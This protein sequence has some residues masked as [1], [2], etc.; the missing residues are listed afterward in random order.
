MSSLNKIKTKPCRI[1]TFGT[2]IPTIA[3]SKSSNDLKSP[4][5]IQEINDTYLGKT[6]RIGDKEGLLKYVGSVHFAKGVWCGIE[7]KNGCGKNNG[8]VNG[9]QYFSCHEHRGLM[10]QASKVVLSEGNSESVDTDNVSGPYSILCLDSTI[11]FGSTP[12]VN[13]TDNKANCTYGVEI[14]TPN[15]T[16]N[17]E[18]KTYDLPNT[19]C[20]IDSDI[21]GLRQTF[22]TE[23]LRGQLLPERTLVHDKKGSLEN[24]ADNAD[25]TFE[26]KR[27]KTSNNS[28]FVASD[29][30]PDLPNHSTPA[31]TGNSNGFKKLRISNIVGFQTSEKDDD[32]SLGLLSLNNI[33]LVSNGENKN[34]SVCTNRTITK[35]KPNSLPQ[36][37]PSHQLQA[38]SN[39]HRSDLLDDLRKHRG[40]NIALDIESEN[41]KRNSL[42]CDESLGILTPDQMQDFTQAFDC[43]K[44]VDIFGTNQPQ[45]TN[46]NQSPLA[47]QH[48]IVVSKI[49]DNKSL[50][51]SDT[52]KTYEELQSPNLSSATD[53]SFGIIDPDQMVSGFT[54]LQT[55]TTMNLNLPLDLAGSKDTTLTRCEET[56]SP[57]E[58]PL[59]ITPIIESEPSKTEPTKS[60]TNSSFITSITSITSLDTG[61]QGD[62]EMSRPASR[63]A[64]NSPLTRRP[65]PRPLPRRPDP[66]TDSDFFTE[67]DADNHEDNQLKGDRRA[68]VIDGTLYGVDPQAAADIYVNNREN[69]DS[70]GVFTDIE[71]G[72]RNDD[73]A[74]LDNGNEFCPETNNNKTT[75]V[76]PSE[77][78]KTISE[79]SQSNI[80][81]VL[82]KT[83]KFNKIIDTSLD[84]SLK[85]NLKKRTAPS[86]GISSPSRMS[87]P[88]RPNKEEIT[89]KKYKMPK[90]EVPSKVK[91]MIEANATENI[92]KKPLHRDTVINKIS[93]NEQNKTNS[94]RSSPRSS[95]LRKPVSNQNTPNNKSRRIRTRIAYTPAPL[96]KTIGSNLQSSINSSLSDLSA[97]T[98]PPK[99]TPGT[100]KKREVQVTQ[101]LTPNKLS[102]RNQQNLNETKKNASNIIPTSS[103]A[104]DNKA[105]RSNLFTSKE[106]KLQK[107][108][109]KSMVKGGRT[110]PSV[111]PPVQQ[112]T[113]GPVKKL[114]PAP[115]ATEALAVL[116]HHLVFNVEAFEVPNLRR[117]VEKLSL[118]AEELRLACRLLDESFGKERLK[119]LTA[120][121]E[122]RVRCQNDIEDLIETHR[123]QIA[124]L[125]SQQAEANEQLRL[126]KNISEQQLNRRHDEQL[127]TLR[128]EL[129]KLQQS[130]EEAVDILREENECIRE[131]IDEKRQE[132]ERANHESAK[133]RK[134][135]ETKEIK[136]KEGV[137]SAK[138]HRDKLKQQIAKL[139]NESQSLIDENKRLREQND[140]LLSYGDDK[141]IAKQEVY[142]LRVVLELKQNEITE[143]RKSLEE[144]R[145]KQQTLEGAEDKASALQARCEDLQHQ[146]QRKYEYEQTLIQENQKLH[147]S[148]K[149]EVHHTRRLSQHNEELQWK[150]RQNKEVFTKVM[151]QAEETVF[152]R[153]NIYSSSFNEKHNSSKSLERAFSFRESSHKGIPFETSSGSR[154]SKNSSI[155]EDEL[156]PPASPI[157]KGVV[158]KSDSVSYV[159]DLDES[160]ELV[161]SRILRRSFRNT[162]PPKNTPT[163]SPCT[164]KSRIRNPLS[165][166][167]SSNALSTNKEE[168]EEPRSSS[169]RNANFEDDDVFLWGNNQNSSPKYLHE[170]KRSELDDNLDLDDDNEV[171]LQ[172]P[173]LPNEM[174]K[175][176]EI[177]ALPS[178]KRLAADAVD[179]NSEDESTSSSQL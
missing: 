56:P 71:S 98:A 170:D 133:L 121:E 81:E 65:F 144:A 152:N 72:L 25:E 134:D 119:H 38:A 179:S 88:R 173:A 10:V 112:M 145:R 24:I 110:S 105:K 95:E 153:S 106:K 76:S 28:T 126:E 13:Q 141:D 100:A 77:S 138:L 8:T 93:K 43:S 101:V 172:L 154:K 2:R 177:L 82:Q 42:D 167:S 114:A 55:D 45:H 148:F 127:S 139:E 124:Q 33:S 104:N 32:S 122:E 91:A 174:D 150:L 75:D 60:K 162:T 163:K 41:S 168:G 11:T 30:S 165:L 62:G 131:Q 70:S 158:E 85:E 115:R 40:I 74:D 97:S 50:L 92:L 52:R 47:E 53:Y 176:N 86:P 89:P 59:D 147:E 146:L 80:H 142:S 35:E 39:T 46:Q 96:K 48:L 79:N 113:K 23:D 9:V 129:D 178:P 16:F 7:L 36:L 6:V 140:R 169:A 171:D 116:V 27:R 123:N 51:P 118:E 4:S 78:T 21:P 63:G 130:H 120:I 111:R 160:P 66:M 58:L 90:R 107:E 44:L 87:F 15:Y 132:L 117:Q 12:N 164:K 102:Y 3:T 34:T 159:L 136:L 157:V 175:R 108:S 151:E 54:I 99:K 84:K 5:P 143:L 161:A 83:A 69:M 22:R 61:Y 26:V 109:S 135:Y 37:R 29:S 128:K 14:D 68:Q 67:S 137:E 19:T 73:D 31:K 1:P 103:P 125:T 156:S 57:E 20:T 18:N 94:M 17:C 64:D 155:F 149:E 49:S 166:S